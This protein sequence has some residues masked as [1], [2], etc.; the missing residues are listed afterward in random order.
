MTRGRLWN[1]SETLI[2]VSLLAYPIAFFCKLLSYPSGTMF[3]SKVSDLNG[4]IQVATILKEMKFPWSANMMT[5]YPH[6]ETFWRW[7]SLTQLLQNISLW[8]FTRLTSPELAT[9]FLIIIYW[10]LTGILVYLLAKQIGADRT[11]AFLAAVACQML[12]WIRENVL[13]H[14][15]Y[16]SII[17]LLTVYLYIRFAKNRNQRNIYLLLL[18]IF[19]VFL[20][21]P[22]WTQ[23]SILIMGFLMAYEIVNGIHSLTVHKLKSVIFFATPV[24]M[25]G[26]TMVYIARALGMFKNSENSS[27]VKLGITTAA[28]IDSFQGSLVDYLRPDRMHLLLPRPAKLGTDFVADT[29]NYGGVIIICLAIGTVLLHLRHKIP[30]EVF[31]LQLL[32]FFLITVSLQT[33][34]SIG[35]VSVPLPSELFRHLMPGIRFFTRIGLIAEALLCCLAA[36]TISEIRKILELRKRTLFTFAIL[37]LL[38][39]DFNPVSRRSVVPDKLLYSKFTKAITQSDNPV[40]L[41]VPLLGRTRLDQSYLQ[42]PMVNSFDSLSFLPDIKGAADQGI[43]A[44]S[45]YLLTRGVSHVLTVDYDYPNLQ[46]WDMYPFL[47]DLKEPYFEEV[48]EETVS[49]SYHW[50]SLHLKLFKVIQ[51][52]N[53]FKFKTV[54]KCRNCLESGY[55]ATRKL[56][57]DVLAPEFGINWVLKDGALISVKPGFT[58]AR[59]T[60]YRVKATLIPAGFESKV[61]VSTGPIE[62]DYTIRDPINGTDIE[63]VLNS[64]EILKLSSLSECLQVLTWNTGSSD[65]RRLCFGIKNLEIVPLR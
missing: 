25:M 16:V 47:F 40:F 5:S 2:L 6:G 53:M 43:E 62:N 49:G 27:S 61:L 65:P 3:G 54:T 50:Y 57:G 8:L 37:L 1:K 15:S 44:F 19:V 13:V 24:L 20:F 14:V 58:E 45:E 55:L 22:Y 17:P 60:K 35:A 4:T 59:P 52:E 21:D 28:Q 11:A 39:I 36:V 48:T 9:I 30:R 41:T 12:P 7:Q 64:D 51:T 63:L 34:F 31:T 38:I 23:F 26:A 10:W 33:R 56:Y 29:I 18:S 42:I 32:T 46:E